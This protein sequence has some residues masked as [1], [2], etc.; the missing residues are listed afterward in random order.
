MKRVQILDDSISHTT[1]EKYESNYSLSCY[2]YIVGQTDFFSLGEETCLG[3]G[4]HRIQTY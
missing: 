1:W 3:E 4:N 2:G